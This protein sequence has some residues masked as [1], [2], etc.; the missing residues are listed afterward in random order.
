MSSS[1]IQAVLPVAVLAVWGCLLLLFDVL[2]PR[3]NKGLTAA[4]AAVGLVI[5]CVP[6]VAEFGRV[7]VAFEGMVIVDNFSQY[8]ALVFLA[9]ALVAIALAH[10]YLRRMGIERGEYYALVLFSTA[11]ML[12]MAQSADLIAVFVALE[13]LSIPLYIM[14]GLARPRF[15][16]EEAA[17]KYFL[18]GSFSSGFVVY[19]IALVFGATG[20]TDLA[21][22]HTA[23]QTGRAD[24]TL[25]TIGA[26]L[27]LVGL[28][29]KVAV[30]PFHMWTPDVYQGSP[31]SATAFMSVGAKAGG[32]AGLLRVFLAAFP[33]LVTTWA[34][35]AAVIAALTMIWGNV[36]AIAQSNMKRML[37]YSS[38]AHAGYLLM[39][40]PAAAN[41]ATTSQAVGGLTFY[42]L[43]YGAANLGAWGVVLAL[44]RTE[45]RG[46]LLEDY[47][48]LL[49]RRPLLAGA[50]VIFM[51]SL[52]GVPPTAGF[53]AKFYL[54]SSVIEAGYLWLALVGV[55]TSLVSAYYYLRL[56]VMM[57]MQTGQPEARSEAWLNA[58]I[59]L[60]ALATLL[61]GLV[62]GKIIQLATQAD[63]HVFVP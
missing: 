22:I 60:T 48:G 14:A 8:M 29:F 58:M 4:L 39:A 55:I 1:D 18:L 35:A 63:L 13:L 16:S 31:S 62:P 49:S 5:A 11:G 27:I 61:L 46:L 57:T 17:L 7:A 9:T 25:V 43:A 12:L 40:L 6:V 59:G 52:I 37:A 36:A 44:E 19:G 30:V 51:L 26:V 42:L 10:D 21:S 53:L 2:R 34:P 45:G 28:G 50:M 54:F 56:V 33:G 47:A 15:E 20:T 23:W 3:P 24:I 41:G 32:F 38:I